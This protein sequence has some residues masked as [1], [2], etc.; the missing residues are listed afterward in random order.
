MLDSGGGATLVQLSICQHAWNT[1]ATCA[2]SI[3]HV[4]QLE[5]SDGCTE[6]TEAVVVASGQRVQA[7]TP[8][9]GAYEPMGQGWH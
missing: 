2:Q 1:S 6:P 9:S 5:Q 8:A 4:G 7:T 3:E